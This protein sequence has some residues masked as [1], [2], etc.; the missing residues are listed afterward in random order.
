MTEDFR[1]QLVYH[2]DL[3]NTWMEQSELTLFYQYNYTSGSMETLLTPSDYFTE[4]VKEI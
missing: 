2:T 3:M 1:M 4:I